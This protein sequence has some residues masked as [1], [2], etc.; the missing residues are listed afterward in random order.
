MELVKEIKRDL[1][2]GKIILGFSLGFDSGASI[3]R[4]G[5]VLASVNEERLSRIKNDKT[6]PRLAI[7][8]CLTLAGLA[9]SEID[10]VA[11]TNYEP[12]TLHQLIKRYTKGGEV[13][14]DKLMQKYFEM[15]NHPYMR[16]ALNIIAKHDQFTQIALVEEAMQVIKSLLGNIGIVPQK[17]NR[18]DHH[19]THAI[20][21][22]YF[23]GFNPKEKNIV[24]TSDGFGDD[25]SS[26]ISVVEDGEL[27]RMNE[28]GLV[29]SIAL[30]YQ[31]VTG[32]LGFTMHKHE[33]K[34]TGLAAYGNPKETVKEFE[35][36]CIL[37]AGTNQFMWKSIVTEDKFPTMEQISNPINNFYLFEEMRDHIF[38]LVRNGGY[39]REDIA[40]GVQQFAENMITQWITNFMKTFLSVK[41]N[42][43]IC[44]SGGLFA[45][46]KINQKIHELPFVKKIFVFPA[47]G[48]TGG[49][50]GAALSHYFTGKDLTTTYLKDVF[51]GS[52]IAPEYEVAKTIIEM[53]VATN[54][55]RIN[56]EKIPGV[57]AFLLAKGNLVA[58]VTGKMEYGPRALTHRSILF[59]CNDRSVNTWLNQ[60]LGRDEIMP[61]APVMK[62]E[63]ATKAFNKMEGAEYTSRFMTVTKDATEF[64]VENCPAAVHIDNT[65]RPQLIIK[66]E[67]E[68]FWD[69]LDAYEKLTG[70]IALIN[71]SYN[72]HNEPI[73]RTA[74]EAITVFLKSNIQYLMLGNFLIKRSDIK[75]PPM[76]LL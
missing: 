26:T 64:F 5:E 74:E 63:N 58:R 23:S 17:L 65:A 18:I 57:L 39:S 75:F 34:V 20:P 16:H 6:F 40:A 24:I 66:E 29:G 1:M 28:S 3:I 50:M 19:W 68:D 69:I 56:T 31:F 11:Y 27:V 48:D 67:N 46:V 41:D 51:F 59:N 45:N 25:L 21:A 9:P 13:R 32:G 12:D 47:M 43:N 53:G 36:L 62:M 42:V 52:D 60:Q 54:T 38:D 37:N 44:L 73:V 30:I 49:G 33:G 8:E 7:Q 2:A 55:V 4:D 71:T 10:I 76:D 70:N 72:V 35:K 22:Y 15:E 14:D 61:Y